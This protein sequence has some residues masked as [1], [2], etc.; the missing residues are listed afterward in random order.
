MDDDRGHD[1]ARVNAT[2]GRGPGEEEQ[3]D[4]V[5]WGDYKAER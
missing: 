3:Y 2:F 5:G 1:T 4:E